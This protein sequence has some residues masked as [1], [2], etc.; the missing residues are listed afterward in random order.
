M[1]DTPISDEA[2]AEAED[3]LDAAAE[4]RS[5]TT[6]GAIFA[7]LTQSD[8]MTYANDKVRQLFPGIDDAEA[9]VRQDREARARQ[10]AEAGDSFTDEDIP[11]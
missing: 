11:Y 7:G 4:Y 2:L 3:L 10:A 8:A 1:T 9:L 6:S 5:E